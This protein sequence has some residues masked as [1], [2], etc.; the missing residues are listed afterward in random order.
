VGTGNLTFIFACLGEGEIATIEADDMAM[1][2]SDQ[3]NIP[4]EMRMRDQS[5]F[6]KKM[7]ALAVGG[8][9]KLVRGENDSGRQM[10]SRVFQ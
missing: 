6:L 10:A 7:T 9:S 8:L 3:F 2:A 5:L 1:F 4:K